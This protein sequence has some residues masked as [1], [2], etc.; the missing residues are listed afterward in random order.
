M[1]MITVNAGDLPNIYALMGS[2]PTDELL[3]SPVRGGRGGG[4][5][6]CTGLEDEP[7]ALLSL[8]TAHP[9]WS[10]LPLPQGAQHKEEASK[11]QM[12]RLRRY[13]VS[14]GASAD[15]L[16]GWSTVCVW[17]SRARACGYRGRALVVIAT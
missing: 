12:R 11:I 9:A 16:D 7:S 14:L 4:A 1:R 13:L 8:G 15:V 5:L 2:L 3:P 6:A 17:T 10:D